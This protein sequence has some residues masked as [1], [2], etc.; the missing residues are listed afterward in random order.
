LCSSLGS[1]NRSVAAKRKSDDVKTA[2][3]SRSRSA[4]SVGSPRAKRN[5]IGKSGKIDQIGT[6][7]VTTRKRI[8]IGRSAAS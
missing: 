1:S 6:M 2:R 3:D 4:M 7:G 8:A 5:G